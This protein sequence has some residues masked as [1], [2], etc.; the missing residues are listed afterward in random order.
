MMGL[1]PTEVGHTGFLLLIRLKEHGL[2][3]AGSSSK[4]LAGGKGWGRW[5]AGP[6]PA[7]QA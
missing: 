5:L 2:V 3:A 6:S 4:R 7:S 1:A